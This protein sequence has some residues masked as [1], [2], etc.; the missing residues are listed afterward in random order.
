M[1]SSTI[2]VQIGNYANYVCSHLWNFQYELLDGPAGEGYDDAVLFRRTE[3]GDAGGVVRTPRAVVCDLRENFVQV[4]P[5]DASGGHRARQLSAMPPPSVW[6]GATATIAR[7]AA[8]ALP[9]DALAG[10]TVAYWSDITRHPYAP[11]SIC[12]M[13]LWTTGARFDSYFAGLSPELVPAGMHEDVAERVRAFAEECDYVGSIRVFADLHDG[14][15][16]LAC[17]AVEALRDD[18]PSTALPVWGFTEGHDPPGTGGGQASMRATLRSLGLPLCYKRL[19]EAASVVVPIG[20]PQAVAAQL[21]PASLPLDTREP[22]QTAAVVAMAIEAATGYQH[23]HHRRMGN[24]SSS[25]SSSSYSSGGGGGGGRGVDDNDGADD[26]RADHRRSDGGGET[27]PESETLPLGPKE[28][29]HVVTRGGTFPLCALEASLPFPDSLDALWATFDAPDP[30]LCGGAEGAFGADART[31]LNPFMRPLTAAA[32]GH[33][34]VPL[35][36]RARVGRAYTNVIGVRCPDCPTTLSSTLFEQCFMTPYM[37]S[38]CQQRQAPVRLHRRRFPPIFGADNHW[39]AAAA[40]VGCDGSMGAHIGVVTDH[41]ARRAGSMGCKAQLEKA[42]M[43]RDD[44]LELKEALL[45]LQRQYSTA[46]E[47]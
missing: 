17:A 16:G 38:S 32:V 25:S 8:G 18:Y 20:N 34:A 4:D 15:G 6:S 42:G 7:E 27:E 14:F 10:S 12:D 23:F 1:S 19:R 9:P 13:P 44:C 5:F 46:Y 21:L 2:T 3:G 40:A 30:L 41:F 45:D 37:L 47:L 36:D 39:V 43:T 29:C 22:Y 24:G 28:W 33:W 26:N 31:T 35:A 11:R